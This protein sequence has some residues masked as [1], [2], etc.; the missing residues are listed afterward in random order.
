ML[1]ML[2]YIM[3]A[4]DEPT[5]QSGTLGVE[6]IISKE[7]FQ[8]D[9]VKDVLNVSRKNEWVTMTEKD[10]I[11]DAIT[12]FTTNKLRGV[13]VVNE[14]GELTSILTQ[15]S[16]IQWLANK[17]AEMGD[18]ANIT[19]DQFKLGYRKVH[20]MHQTRRVIDIFLQMDSLGISSFGIVNKENHLLGN[21]SV[22]DLKDIGESAENFITLWTDAT[23][24]INS[25]DYGAK[26]PKLVY[27]TPQN[28]VKELLE[29]F[30]SFDI[31]RV[32]VV[33][34]TTHQPVGIISCTDLIVFFKVALLGAG[35]KKEPS[36]V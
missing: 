17:T 10:S 12:K 34:K 20:C 19:I 32:Y 35:G 23:N 29:K 4:L 8:K 3:R 1:D 9:T 11:F 27:V 15:F 21:I 6:D 13:A 30:R 16:L 5:I 25:R 18:I 31:H 26:V 24:F 33:E 36:K 7:H 2:S 22:S 14:K 28:T